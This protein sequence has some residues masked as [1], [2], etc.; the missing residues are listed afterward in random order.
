[1]MIRIANEEKAPLQYM[2]ADR[3]GLHALTY[4]VHEKAWRM[5]KLSSEL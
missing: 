5:S 2:P 1:M 4:A 3:L